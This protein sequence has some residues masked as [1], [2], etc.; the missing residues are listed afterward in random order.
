MTKREITLALN[1]ASA[2]VEV[3]DPVTAKK[4]LKKNSKNRKINMASVNTYAKELMNGNWV[5][6]GETIII[7][8]KGHILDGQHRLKA[9]VQTGMTIVCVVVRGIKES[10]FDTLDQGWKRS[11]GQILTIEGYK[12][13]NTLAATIKGVYSYDKGFNLKDR[14]DGAFTPKMMKT[15]MSG[16]KGI[17][18]SVTFAMKHKKGSLFTQTVVASLHFIFSRINKDD[19]TLFMNAILTGDH[20]GNME[21]LKLRNHFINLKLNGVKINRNRPYVCGVLIKGWNA[22]RNNKKMH[23]FEYKKG[24]TFP[25]AI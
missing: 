16:M 14:I 12:H 20:K 22:F 1:S 13:G 21:L 2:N 11:N 5:F 7:S 6:N 24:D 19:A 23:D 9:V 3:I 18:N 10:A 4:Y 8:S 17:E 15:A 25:K